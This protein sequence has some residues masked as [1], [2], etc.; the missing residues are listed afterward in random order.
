MGHKAE[1]IRGPGRC[2]QHLGVSMIRSRDRMEPAGG[3]QSKTKTESKTNSE[4]SLGSKHR[5]KGRT[6]VWK[7]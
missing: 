3:G 4:T 6:N 1:A 5:L 2:E 7:V